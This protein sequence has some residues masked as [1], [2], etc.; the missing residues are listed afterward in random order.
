M[1]PGDL[2]GPGQ[3]PQEAGPQAPRPIVVPARPFAAVSVAPG[4]AYAGPRR[5][6]R[7]PP[8]PAYA[9]IYVAPRYVYPGHFAPWGSLP[10]SYYAASIP[11]PFRVVQPA[12]Y[13]ERLDAAVGRAYRPPDPMPGESSPPLVRQSRPQSPGLPIL[14]PPEPGPE[15]IPAP[16]PIDAPAS[17]S[18]SQSGSS[19]PGGG[20]EVR[21]PTVAAE[22]PAPHATP[23]GIPG[24]GP[25][26]F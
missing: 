26:E 13:L 21:V 2:Q 17:S 20:A 15:A 23:S 16:V 10:F 14:S 11:I 22:K 9:G 5:A 24:D 4:A 18:S 25:R 1:A 12:G 8:I 3:A 19:Q 6:Y 7:R